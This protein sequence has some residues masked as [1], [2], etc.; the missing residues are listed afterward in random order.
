[1]APTPP[2]PPPA[3]RVERDERLMRA[4]F[5]LTYLALGAGVV[6]AV[7]RQLSYYA[8]GRYRKDLGRRR[9]YASKRR[10][11]MGKTAEIA[12]ARERGEGDARAEVVARGYANYDQYDLIEEG[13]TDPGRGMRYAEVSA[14][15][16]ERHAARER[17]VDALLHLS[18]QR[19]EE[20][21][22]KLEH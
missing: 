4:M 1:M 20:L 18:R 14:E 21:A 3:M 22:E 16:D 15:V 8:C 17:R 11:L 9:A 2:P 12:K 13:G 5:A 19:E 10:A 6:A 7:W